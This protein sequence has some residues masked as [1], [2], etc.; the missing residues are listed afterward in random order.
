MSP[1]ILLSLDVN[2][3]IDINETHLIKGAAIRCRR[4]KHM[5]SL[6]ATDMAASMV[7]PVQTL[8]RELLISSHLLWSS[9]LLAV[10]VQLRWPA[11]NDPF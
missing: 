4:G 6:I 8:H 5:S 10:P 3:D 2:I 7:R 11:W 9:R 1:S